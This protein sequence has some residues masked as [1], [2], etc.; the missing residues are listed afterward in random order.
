M[1]KKFFSR[2]SRGII[3]LTPLDVAAFGSLTGLI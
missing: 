3:V 1:V 2:A